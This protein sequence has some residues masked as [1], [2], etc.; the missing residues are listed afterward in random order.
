M[1]LAEDD[2]PLF[3]PVAQRLGHLLIIILHCSLL[4]GLNWFKAGTAEFRTIDRR[5]QGQD[6]APT[7]SS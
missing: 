3:E 1:Y 5:E 6:I 2:S 4:P 7:L